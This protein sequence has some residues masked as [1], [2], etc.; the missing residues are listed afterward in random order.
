MTDSIGRQLQTARENRQMTVFDVAA[1]TLIPVWIV[2]A[3]EKD[4]FEAMPA[5]LYAR[6]FIKLYARCVGLDPAPLVKAYDSPGARKSPAEKPRREMA[7]KLADKFLFPRGD[8]HSLADMKSPE[9]FPDGVGAGA[10]VRKPR[11]RIRMP[12]MRRPP[13]SL[14]S[15]VA[16][17]EAMGLKI[18]AGLLAAAALFRDVA[19]RFLAAAQAGVGKAI[20]KASTLRVPRARLAEERRQN[21]LIIAAGSV[22]V[23]LIVLGISW[24]HNRNRPRVFDSRM[25]QDPPAP[26]IE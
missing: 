18:R 9:V 16:R 1:A 25:V 5:P 23:V 3:I 26:Y 13:F 20:S 8:E 17:L 24:H 7:E 11:F 14:R 4:D 19:A 6:G 10:R 22:L 21:I 2:S 12:R 15:S